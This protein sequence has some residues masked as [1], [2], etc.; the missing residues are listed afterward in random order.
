MQNN[1]NNLFAL[2]RIKLALF[3]I[4]PMDDYKQKLDELLLTTAKQNASDLHLAVGRRPTLRID[5][6]LVPLQKETILT[7][8]SAE[9]LIS[10]FLTPEQ[11][12]EFLKNK[13]HDLSYS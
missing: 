9:C 6:A 1:A 7:P 8:E 5:G 3:T 4:T 13:E 11:K 12:E 10:A 2:F